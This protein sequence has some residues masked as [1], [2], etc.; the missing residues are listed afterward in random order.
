MMLICLNSQIFYLAGASLARTSPAVAPEV[1]PLRCH[2]GCMPFS[3]RPLPGRALRV[4]LAAAG[5]FPVHFVCAHLV[6]AEGLSFEALVSRV[7]ARLSPLAEAVTVF[8]GDLNFARGGEGR[9]DVSMGAVRFERGRRAEHFDEVMAVYAEILVDGYFRRQLRGGDIQRLS[10]LDR[11]FLN[12]HSHQLQATQ[13]SSLFFSRLLDATLPS[14]HVVELRFGIVG[15]TR[16]RSLPQRVVAHPMFSGLLLEALPSV[17]DAAADSFEQISAV[18]ALM[19]HIGTRVIRHAPAPDCMHVAA[20]PAHWLLVARTSW[21]H[22]DEAAVGRVV[23]RLGGS[24]AASLFVSP[25]GG[26]R[27]RC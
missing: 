4:R 24:E 16:P 11:F 23:G 2:L 20:W 5:A 6:D 12:A 26:L 13:C 27:E 10:K 9:L 15:S 25:E 1:W 17:I 18:T 19:H 21:D 14:D 8:G 7:R 22:G 3:R